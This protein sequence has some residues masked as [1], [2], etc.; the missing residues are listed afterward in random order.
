V[1]IT[2]LRSLLQASASQATGNPTFWL[3][4][5]GSIPGQAV[6]IISTSSTKSFKWK[7]F[8]STRAPRLLSLRARKATAANPVMNITLMPGCSLAARRA[9]SSAPG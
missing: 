9:S 7:G 5:A 4:K 1:A 6:S 8:D 2:T 3:S